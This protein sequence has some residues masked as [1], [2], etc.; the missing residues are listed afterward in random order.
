VAGIKT[1]LAGAGAGGGKAAPARELFM[2]ATAAEP[3][4]PRRRGVWLSRPKAGNH[5]L[6]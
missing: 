5:G 3:V 6:K 4:V 2:A 1:D